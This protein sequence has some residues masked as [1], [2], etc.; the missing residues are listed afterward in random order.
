MTK[1]NQT[2]A[3]AVS[4]GFDK[5]P[6]RSYSL[7]ADAYTQ[8][9]WFDADK[10]NI[11]GRSWQ[12]VCHVEKTREPGSYATAEIAGQPIAVVRDKNGALR[13]FYNVCKHRAHQPLPCMGL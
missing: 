2:P 4:A 12:W 8:S 9:E 13:A 5:D 3:S 11:I 6:A 1:Q 7:H 10:K